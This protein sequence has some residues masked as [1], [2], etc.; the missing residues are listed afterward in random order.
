PTRISFQVTNK[1][2][3]RTILGEQGAEQLLG[4]GDMLFMQGGARI[5]RVHGP[6]I[7]D[8]EVE[9]V[10]A[11]LRSKGSPVYNTEV[12]ADEQ[13]EEEASSSSKGSGK[14]SD[15]DQDSALYEQATE[16][17]VRA[18]RAST[19]FVQRHLRIGYNRA[20]NII[21]QMEREGI[22]SAANHVGKRDVLATKASLGLDRHDPDDED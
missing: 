12:L 20:A 3:S 7:S 2:D 21:D 11:D 14:G 4:R 16:L 18:Q 10:V 15:E 5:T 17:V 8:E 6:F 22:I 19:S 13:E 9:A 1:Y